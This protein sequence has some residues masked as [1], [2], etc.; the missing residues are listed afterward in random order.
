MSVMVDDLARALS[1]AIAGLGPGPER[2]RILVDVVFDAFDRDGAAALAAWIMLSHKERVLEPIRDAVH[3]LGATVDA[4][5]AQDH[6]ERSG[7]IPSAL[8]F[9]ALCAFADAL[10]G[11]ELTS[12]LQRDRDTMR[13]VATKLLPRFF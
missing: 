5:L 8:L 9:L 1:D 11:Q 2:A 3:A 7:H 10:V 4:K 6:G 13:Q 12:M